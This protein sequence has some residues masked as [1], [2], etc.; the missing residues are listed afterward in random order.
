MAGLQVRRAQIHE[1]QIRL[2]AC[3]QQAG[4]AA[5]CRAMRLPEGAARSDGDFDGVL[6]RQRVLR[7]DRLEY[8]LY[9][10]ALIVHAHGGF[11]KQRYRLGGGAVV[12]MAFPRS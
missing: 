5:L 8:G 3:G 4:V 7:F 12:T 2:I 11:V 6:N 9:V 1:D 10:A